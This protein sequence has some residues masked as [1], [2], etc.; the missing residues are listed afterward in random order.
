MQRKTVLR[1][2]FVHSQTGVGIHIEI[3][4]RIGT[5][6]T[7]Q[8]PDNVGHVGVGG[9]DGVSTGFQRLLGDVL[10]EV[11]GLGI[12][13]TAHVR[14]E[15]HQIGLFLGGPDVGL[16]LGHIRGAG[17]LVHHVVG[18]GIGVAHTQ[19]LLDPAPAFR[20]H[21]LEKLIHP[22]LI[23][24]SAGKIS[25]CVLV[26]QQVHG[27]GIF[28]LSKAVAAGAFVIG[29]V[30]I[31]DDGD[32]GVAHLVIECFGPNFT[33]QRGAVVA[34]ALGIQNL[35]GADHALVT[36]VKGVVIG[37]GDHFDACGLYSIG[38]FIRCVEAVMM[39]GVL[40]F[41]T[42]QRA[43][44]IACNIVGF[45]QQRP[46]MGK[47]FTEIILAAGTLCAFQHRRLA[48]NVA[49]KSDLHVSCL[50]LEKIVVL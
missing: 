2:I 49:K 6:D 44:Q 34:D 7:V 9:N 14:I 22:V 10:G 25:G 24:Q 18:P 29:A 46:N 21:F 41:G 45:I 15:E 27:A 37:S 31:G 4:Q 36:T 30:G 26:L 48:H 43:F 32:L 50:L 38:V 16:D 1:Q 13:L 42:G 19:D 47:N 23:V 35:D 17:L 12:E 5:G 11:A 20:I 8:L 40:D 3:A 33:R 28:A 39:L